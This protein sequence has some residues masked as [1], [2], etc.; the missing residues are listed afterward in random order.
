MPDNLSTHRLH[1]SAF[2]RPEEIDPSDP[3]RIMFL[4]VE[5]ANT[6]RQ[7]FGH[8]SKYI[9]SRGDFV[10]H[11]KILDR[12]RSD[13]R[14]APKHVVDLIDEYLERIPKSYEGDVFAAIFDRDGGSGGRSKESI[15]TCIADCDT[16][17]YR[18]YL[19]NPCFEFWLLLHLC[20]VKTEYACK[21]A[22][23]LVNNRVS[24]KHTFVSNEVSIRANH[25]KGITEAKFRSTYLPQIS[26]AM[27]YAESFSTKLE[28]ILDNL[29][30]N[31]SELFHELK[32]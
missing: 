19:T 25:A 16:K 24:S 6:E 29:G 1:S 12:Y 11:V 3:K 22:E 30:T 32:F 27:I 26:Q 5:G 10:F 2:D 18:I 15:E 20:N 13:G 14:S 21:L 28:D 7:Y 4:S 8:L 17:G 23:L 31:L 9:R